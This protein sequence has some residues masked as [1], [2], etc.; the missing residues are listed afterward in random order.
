MAT[1]LAPIRYFTPPADGSRP[2]TDINANLDDDDGSSRNFTLDYHNFAIRDFRGAEHEASLDVSGFQFAKHE[3]KEKDFANEEKIKSEYYDES[4]ELLKKL[5]GANRVVIFDHTIRRHRPD[6]HEN[7]PD[8]RQ[9]VA[10]AHVDQTP[11]SAANR[12]KRHLPESDVPTLLSK[13]FQIINLWRPIKHEAWDRPL[14]LCDFRSINPDED[15]IRTTL[16]YPDYEGET[17]SVKHSPNHKWGYLKGM[18]PSEIV[19]IKCFDSDNN[20]AVLTPHTSFVDPTTPEGSPLRE[21]I[22]LRALVFYD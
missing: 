14:S 15:L 13:R 11:E 1:V 4:I 22:E 3:S 9:P 8:K 17:Y 21:S 7:T 6:V 18:S 16:K 10:I 19:L 20:Y 5:T 2:W 12:V